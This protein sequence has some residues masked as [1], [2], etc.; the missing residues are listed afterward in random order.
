MKYKSTSKHVSTIADCALCQKLASHGL[1]KPYDDN[2]AEGEERQMADRQP[3]KIHHER[4]SESL[5]CSPP[6][7]ER[8]YP[9]RRNP[10]REAKA[11]YQTCGKNS[12]PNP[13]HILL[14]YIHQGNGFEINRCSRIYFEARARRTS[15]GMTNHA[16]GVQ[17]LTACKDERAGLHDRPARE[18]AHRVAAPPPREG[19]RMISYC[20]FAAFCPCKK[21]PDER[22]V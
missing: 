19:E 11:A 21:L 14:E 20:R 8:E 7:R 2:R 12:Y 5:K 1:K 10:R 9:Y 4:E 17:S 18:C 16:D 13:R 6:E 15:F 3:K 22:F